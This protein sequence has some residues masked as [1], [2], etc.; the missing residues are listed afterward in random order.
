[1][2]MVGVFGILVLLYAVANGQEIS[3]MGRQLMSPNLA[4][5]LAM[6]IALP[7][8]VLWLPCLAMPFCAVVTDNV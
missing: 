6:A 8:T 3:I 5:L 4:G 1:M 2:W 7:V